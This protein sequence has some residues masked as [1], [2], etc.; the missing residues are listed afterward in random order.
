[1]ANDRARARVA[2]LAALISFFGTASARAQQPLADFLGAADAGN[3][4]VRAARAAVSQSRSQVDEAR[5]RLLP[6]ATASGSYQRNELE[7]VINIPDSTTGGVRQATISPFDQLDAR[8]TLGVPLIDL[9]AWV[10]FF[11]SEATADAAEERADLALREARAA[12]VLLWHQLVASRLL[13]GAA[14]RSLAVAEHNRANASARV[15]V[16]VA[17]VLELARADA[18]VERARQAVAEARLAA[19]LGARNLEN[20]TGLAAT[21]AVQS[22][23]D[24]LREEPPLERFRGGLER[25]PAVRAAQADAL[26]AERGEHAA[27]FALAPTVNAQITERV[28]N[29]AGFG[30][31]SQWLATLTATWQLDFGRPAAIGTRGAVAAG[32]RVRLAQVEQQIDTQVF[33]LW[34]RVR[35]QRARSAASRAALA[36][37]QRAAEDARARFETGAATQLDVIQAERDLFAAE[38][39][40]IQAIAD[41]RV[42]RL[43]LRI[44][45]GVDDE[46]P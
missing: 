5:A 16:G 34:E 35:T 29:A 37:S 7:V 3:L 8:F 6:F 24:D 28:T 27:W 22:L 9:G 31:N 11:A 30:P 43:L 41:L 42:A 45:S 39:A 23:D 1:M 40:T 32:A 33:E 44:R 14:E 25:H 19:T 26:A 12:V 20:A 46:L 10:G 18:E 38:V 2:T 4:D 17:P 13:V 15:E 21:G 36:A